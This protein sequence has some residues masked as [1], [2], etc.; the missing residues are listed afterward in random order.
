MDGDY[1]SQEA[2][3]QF[4]DRLRRRPGALP[5]FGAVALTS[6]SA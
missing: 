6:R 3:R 4:Y 2:R 1:P 5:E